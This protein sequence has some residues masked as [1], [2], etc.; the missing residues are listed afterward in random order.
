MLTTPAEA[1]LP[2]SVPCGPRSTSTRS[3]SYRSPKACPERPSTTLSTTV[4]TLGSAA[5]LNEIVPIPRIVSALLRVVLPVRKLTDGTSACNSSRL[6]ANEASICWRPSTETATGTSLMFS[7]RFCAVMTISSITDCADAG[8]VKPIC[9]A[10]A[11]DTANATPLSRRIL[12]SLKRAC[13][14]PVRAVP[15]P[16]SPLPSSGNRA[17]L[18]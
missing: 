5:T 16:G 6:L 12:S 10:T 15:M 18:D 11:I 14:V 3:R 7:S 1:F 13:V 8:A 17:G 9:K 2:N 4:D